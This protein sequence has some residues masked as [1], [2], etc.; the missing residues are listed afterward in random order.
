MDE[1]VDSILLPFLFSFNWAVGWFRWKPLMIYIPDR[2]WCGIFPLLN[3]SREKKNLS[4]FISLIRIDKKKKNETEMKYRQQ[5]WNLVDLITPVKMAALHKR[6]PIAPV[7]FSHR[8][9]PFFQ[10]LL[11]VFVKNEFRRVVQLTPRG[12]KQVN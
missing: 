7:D 8:P 5:F 10:F 1:A 6:C 2:W 3:S 12:L 9:K 11:F 4:L